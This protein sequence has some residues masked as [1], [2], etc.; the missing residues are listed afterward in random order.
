MIESSKRGRETDAYKVLT[1]EM[2]METLLS[3][4]YYEFRPSSLDTYVPSFLICSLLVVLVTVLSFQSV[5]HTHTCRRY[6][7]LSLFS[8]SSSSGDSSDSSDTSSAYA[9]ELD[10]DLLTPQPL[11]PSGLATYISPLIPPTP[12]ITTSSTYPVTP[13]FDYAVITAGNQTTLRGKNIVVDDMDVYSDDPSGTGM[14]EPVDSAMC[15]IVYEYDS[16]GLGVWFGFGEDFVCRNVDLLVPHHPRSSSTTSSTSSI[17]DG[18][19]TLSYTLDSN[20][21]ST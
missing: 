15:Y 2:E 9:I 21:P 6:N 7:S 3:N 18:N 14:V 12:W 11:P 5:Q 8:S 17:N 16:L 10:S 4:L 1:R 13:T 19:I 20:S